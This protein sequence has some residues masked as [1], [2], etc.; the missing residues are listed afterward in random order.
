MGWSLGYMVNATEEIAAAPPV[1]K[2]KVLP[3]S[4]LT[5][6]FIIFVLL[7]IGFSIH[8]FKIRKNSPGYQRL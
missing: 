6:L 4:L 1:P 7:G 2:L 8:G 3:F 5:V